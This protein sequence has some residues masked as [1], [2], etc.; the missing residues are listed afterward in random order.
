MWSASSRT[1]ISTFDS[2]AR[3]AA[4]GRARGRDSPRRSPE[5]CRSALIC[6]PHRDTAVDRG[7]LDPGEARE[8]A[9]LRVD[10][11]GELAGGGQDQRP[12]IARAG[13]LEQPLEEGQREGR[14]LAG[15]GL[16]QA[17][18]VSAR[19]R[20]GDRL[21]PGSRAVPRSRPRARRVRAARQP[22]L[23]ESSRGGRFQGSCRSK[24]S[25]SSACACTKAHRT[26]VWFR[27]TQQQGQEKGLGGAT[28]IFEGYDRRGGPVVRR[29]RADARL[30]RVCSSR[31]GFS[32]TGR[33]RGF[34]SGG[35]G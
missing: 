5:G 15:A 11:L 23:F 22:E 19:E 29:D 34:W 16:C 25:H 8:Q 31:R 28:S 30:E 35:L 7:G 24:M 33:V 9:D 10:L 21:R 3:A 26:A 14:R 27:P 2:A 12:G 20:R 4:R 13:G 18:H 6:V 1:R 32:P 17:E